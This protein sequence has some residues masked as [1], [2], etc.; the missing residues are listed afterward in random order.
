[1]GLFMLVLGVILWTDAHLLKTVLPKVRAGMD[2]RL[3]A[4]RARG[5]MALIMLS[6]IILMIIG[7]RSAEVTQIYSPAGW[8]G[9]VN[10]LLM[11]VAILLLGMGS[12]KGRLRSLLRHPMLTGVLVWVVAHLLV[13]GDLA[14]IILFG[15]MALWAISHMVL[16]NAANRDWVRPEP[17]PAKGDAK[18]FVIAAVLYVVI[19]GI[20]TMLGYNPFSGGY[21]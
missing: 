10:N 8:A 18:L 11:F 9:P 20:H 14:S 1:M 6:G 3:G 12:S 5:I 17:G 19:V 16:L 4:G 13:N 7:Y 15:G 2:D 21:A